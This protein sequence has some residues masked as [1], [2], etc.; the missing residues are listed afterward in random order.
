MADIQHELD[1]RAIL[2][3]LIARRAALAAGVFL[4]GIAGI[5]IAFSTQDLYQANAILTF[6]SNRPNSTQLSKPVKEYAE[7]AHVLNT[8]VDTIG[9]KLEPIVDRFLA[10]SAD[11]QL[12]LRTLANSREQAGQL[13]KTWADIV[14]RDEQAQSA[15]IV[16]EQREALKKTVDDAHKE[17]VDAQ[18][19]LTKFVKEN[20][21]FEKLD[22]YPVFDAY[23]AL[24]SDRNDKVSEYNKL[25]A[26]QQLFSK[27]DVAPEDIFNSPRARKDTALDDFHKQLN[28]LNLQRLSLPKTDADGL[29]NLDEKINAT[30]AAMLEA[31]HK[32]AIQVRID[33]D[34]AKLVLDQL[35]QKAQSLQKD[36]SKVKADHQVYTGLETE[37]KVAEHRYTDASQK[38]GDFESTSAALICKVI[39]DG[40]KNTDVFRKKEYKKYTILGIAGGLFISLMLVGLLEVLKEPEVPPPIV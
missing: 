32:Y 18:N 5:L 7:S 10:R 31:A 24:S 9:P 19:K 14:A 34:H 4:G 37:V 21:A 12:Y 39:E 25:V 15:G 30:R 36:M 13:A 26:E 28:E 29:H 33:I 1:L 6:D 11:N 17:L 20:D 35:N 27:A 38:L 3:I 8:V 16:Q 40:T 22:D 23:R 2:K